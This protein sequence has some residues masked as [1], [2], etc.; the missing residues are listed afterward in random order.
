MIVVDDDDVICEWIFSRVRERGRNWMDNKCVRKKLKNNCSLLQWSWDF[1]GIFLW[2]GRMEHTVDG[3]V[4][5]KNWLI[6][7][8][9][10]CLFIAW[11]GNGS[12]NWILPHSNYFF[13]EF[14]ELSSLPSFVLGVL[15][16][17]FNDH[18]N[19]NSFHIY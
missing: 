16:K 12:S 7:R 1:Q 19:W 11:R 9:F 2:M 14:L 3:M 5:E 17:V 10:N 4:S 15:K 18:L 13:I 8:Y 6:L